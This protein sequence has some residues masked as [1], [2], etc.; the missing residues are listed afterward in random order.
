MTN[1]TQQTYINAPYNS[2]DHCNKDYLKT[3][4]DVN[5][6]WYSRRVMLQ[7]RQKFMFF[8]AGSVDLPE[9]L[10]FKYKFERT[11]WRFGKRK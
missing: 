8:A 1:M 9:K 2:K 4:L 5:I 6:K 3:T 7:K 11:I 10:N